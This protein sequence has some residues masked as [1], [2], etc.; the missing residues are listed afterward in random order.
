MLIR[1]VIGDPIDH[2]LGDILHQELFHQL[3]IEGKYSKIHVSMDELENFT[4]KNKVQEYNVTIPHKERIIQFLG[5]L[6]SSAA[7][8]GA[9]N[10]VKDNKGYNTDWL[11]FKECIEQ[12]KINVN[13][14]KCLI[15]GAGGAAKAVAYALIKLGTRSLRVIN[16]SKEKKD[17]LENW[18]RKQGI[19]IDN[20][21]DCDIIINCTPVGMWPRIDESPYNLNRVT[22][23]QT[24][25]D[26]IYNPSETKLVRHCKER[27]DKAMG[28]LDMFIYQA[29]E[30]L[31]IW[32]DSQIK[33]KIDIR[34]IKKEL[35]SKL[36]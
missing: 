7:Q 27:A 5:E 33:G 9:V 25:I 1:G 15:L 19:K 26:T 20:E 16:R 14:Q 23:S 29:I 10:C 36:C 31:A 18:I 4:S 32:E 21:N 17:A 3:D 30:S 6:D 8:I 35:R 11:G 13:Q 24:I 34:K 22:K 2:S 28:G 12:N